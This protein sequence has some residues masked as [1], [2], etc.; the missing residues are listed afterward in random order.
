MALV[1]RIIRGVSFTF[2]RSM[3]SNIEDTLHDKGVADERQYFNQKDKQALA[4]LLKKMNTHVKEGADLEST[5]KA[6]EDRLQKVMNKHNLHF[7]DDLKQD[8]LRWKR[9]EI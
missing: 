4:S 5:K 9:G 3:S 2:T 8:L 6:Q 7:S 1:N